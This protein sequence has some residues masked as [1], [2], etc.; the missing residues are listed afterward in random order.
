V[1]D[2][3]DSQAAQLETSAE[4]AAETAGIVA[5]R[6]DRDMLR[7][8]QQPTDAEAQALWV[9]WGQV[10]SQVAQL[11]AQ[12]E[13]LTTAVVRLRAD[14]TELLGTVTAVRNLLNTATDPLV[15]IEQARQRLYDTRTKVW[16]QNR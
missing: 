1:P 14:R 16:Q 5:G 2:R 7:L 3:Y 11:S 13:L 4:L 15:H 12:V 9:T 6:A 8:R 10:V